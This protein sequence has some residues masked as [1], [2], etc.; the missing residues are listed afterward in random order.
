[1]KKKLLSLLVLFALI[2]SAIGGLT[3]F[4][5]VSLEECD[6]C[7]QTAVNGFLERDDVE[8]N[9]VTAVRT[10][11][12][13]INLQHLGYVYEFEL[14]GGDGYAIIICDDGNYIAQEFV[15]HTQSPY[16]QVS[17]EELCIY[18]NSMTYLKYNGTAFC[19]IHSSAE[20][21]SEVLQILSENAIQYKQTSYPSQDQ[22]TIKVYYTSRNYDSDY[23]SKMTPHYTNPGDLVN[24]C[25]AIAGTNLLG[26]YDRY[27][28]NLI[29]NFT[30][31]TEA[32]GMYLYNLAD[33][34]VYN[35]MRELYSDM[36]GNSAG[37]SETNF[38][39]GLQKYCAKKNL[40][41]D[42]TQ[43]LSS[44]KLSFASVKQCISENKPLALLLSTYTVCDI[45]GYSGYDSH[46]Y[47]YFYGNHI[48]IGFGYCEI[49][50]TLTDGSN[51]NYQYVYVA[52]GLGTPDQGYFNINYSTNINSAYKVYIH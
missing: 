43:L 41:C 39:S 12:Y 38:K 49:N 21:S 17:N 18:V 52:S 36:G 5:D 3:A 22:Q 11:V 20:V 33:D 37:I 14:V 26:F 48:M 32:Y 9:T 35:A 44:G 16:A 47:N 31:G 25:A 6:R 1:M 15:P 29:P 50:Y 51:T 2:L 40:S 23:L 10:P 45:D 34:N 46:I 19:D 27:Y 30:A 28:D 4:A 42:F 8:G 13:D 24:A 7:F